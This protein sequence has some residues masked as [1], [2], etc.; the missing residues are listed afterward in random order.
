MKITLS[1]PEK[2]SSVNIINI[3]VMNQTEENLSTYNSH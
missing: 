1:K 3:K 2:K